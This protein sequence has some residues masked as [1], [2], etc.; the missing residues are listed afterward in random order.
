MARL[1]QLSWVSAP[2]VDD[3]MPGRR[4]PALESPDAERAAGVR[5][6]PRLK[7]PRW[8]PRLKAPGLVPNAAS[9]LGTPRCVDG[10]LNSITPQAEAQSR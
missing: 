2:R 9:D 1:P 8:K 10:K 6:K 3:L 5:L 4:N 7:A